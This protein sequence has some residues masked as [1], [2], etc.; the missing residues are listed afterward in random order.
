MVKQGGIARSLWLSA[1]LL[2]VGIGFVGMFV[3]LLP[4]TDFMLLAIPCF[5][6]SSPRLEGWLLHHPRF[7]PS[8]RAWR[9]EGAV[10][11]RAKIAACIGMT[12]G[13]LLFCLSARPHW[14]L[15]LGVAILLIGVAIWIVRRPLPQKHG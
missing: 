2:L 5:A 4:T 3:P 7:G 12:L 15:A 1:G 13:Y 10:P 9:S 14:P 6:K 11:R 8:L